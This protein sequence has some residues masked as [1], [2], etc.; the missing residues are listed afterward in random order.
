LNSSPL[1]LKPFASLG[2]EKKK[3]DGNW[4]T[5]VSKRKKWANMIR[6]HKKKAFP[7]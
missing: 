4:T 2:K 3:N 1:D 7:V 5:V 6:G